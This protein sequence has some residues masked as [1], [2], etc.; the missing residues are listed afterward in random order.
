MKMDVLD[1][2]QN[3]S[4]NWIVLMVVLWVVI[5]P[6]PRL[7]VKS[8]YPHRENDKNVYSVPKLCWYNK[9]YLRELVPLEFPGKH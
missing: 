2:I 9:G 7:Y 1:A 8:L 3:V 5:M 6:Q 4:A